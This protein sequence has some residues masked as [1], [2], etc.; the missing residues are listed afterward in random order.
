MAAE[1]ES[2]GKRAR[3]R[4]EK[5]AVP[6]DHRTSAF[7]R[8]CFDRSRLLRKASAQ[9][10]H[11]IS[12]SVRL[13]MHV[14]VDLIGYTTQVSGRRVSAATSQWILKDSGGTRHGRAVDGEAE[15]WALEDKEQ[16]AAARAEEEL[17]EEEEEERGAQ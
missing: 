3:E 2:T 8:L 15:K 11:C 16:A 7:T 9:L 4:V 14:S 6:F 10:R 12:D 5:S 1:V 13:V 17:E